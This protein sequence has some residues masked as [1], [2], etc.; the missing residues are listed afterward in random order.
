MEVYVYGPLRTATGE[1]VV[2]VPADGGTVGDLL[3]AFLGE[4][5]RTASQLV[6]DDGGLRPSVRVMVDDEKAT[7][8]QPVSKHDEVKIF[9]AMRGG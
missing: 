9:P 8:D 5:P 6:D 1:K 4:Y 7:W 2:D 3:E